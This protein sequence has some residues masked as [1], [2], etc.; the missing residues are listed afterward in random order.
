[1]KVLV[2]PDWRAGNPYLELNESAVRQLDPLLKFQYD[3]FRHGVFSLFPAWLRSGGAR[4]IH[5]HWLDELV[6]PILWSRSRTLARLK[7]AAIVFQVSALRLIGVRIV[8][9]LHNLHS[10]ESLNPQLE[11]DVLSRIANSVS[12]VVVH[13]ESAAN[14][15]EA[16]YLSLRKRKITIIEHPN[17]DG[18]YANRDDVI[19]NINARRSDL[20]EL[21]FFGNIRPYKGVEEAVDAMAHLSRSDIQLTIAGAVA[22]APLKKR[23][24]EAAHRNPRISL[25]LGKINDGHVFELFSKSDVVIVPFRRTLTSG[26]IVLAMT[27]G[28]PVI[29]TP[30]AKVLDL[31]DNTNGYLC[32]FKEMPALLDSLDNTTLSNMRIAA[33]TTADRLDQSSLGDKLLRIYR[34]NE[35]I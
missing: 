21:L 34:K 35:Y 5:L 30:E 23:L 7:V 18:F 1:M 19:S 22:D 25:Q 12:D 31:I 13:S 8:L 28:R 26:S 3:G 20:I 11:T 6:A 14:R 24:Q 10:H 33:R 17:Y 2:M 29:S 4:V 16:T 32:S 15:V 27:M 9:T